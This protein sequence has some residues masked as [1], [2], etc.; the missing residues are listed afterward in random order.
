MV[1]TKEDKDSFGRWETFLVSTVR[2]KTLLRW[3]LLSLGVST[4]PLTGSQANSSFAQ[5]DRSN[6]PREMYLAIDKT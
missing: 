3:L 5:G 6:H 4:Q 1:W 2:T